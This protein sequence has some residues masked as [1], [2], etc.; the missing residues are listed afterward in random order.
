MT[1]DDELK[2]YARAIA[3][4]R[5]VP[6]KK[7][8]EIMRENAEDLAIDFAL[9]EDEFEDELEILADTWREP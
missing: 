2:R 5:G 8:L 7:A 1:L 4:K 3:A 9:D 6:I